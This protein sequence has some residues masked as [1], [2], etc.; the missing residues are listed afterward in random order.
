L[1][2]TEGKIYKDCN[3]FVREVGRGSGVLER[4]LFLQKCCEGEEVSCRF[5]NSI[6][7][8]CCQFVG[9]VANK[10]ATNP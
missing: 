4:S 2:F 3:F 5:T 9:R 6:T 10:S 8:T 7:T 1:I